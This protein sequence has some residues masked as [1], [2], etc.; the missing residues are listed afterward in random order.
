MEFLVPWRNAPHFVVKNDAVKVLVLN[1]FLFS[2]THVINIVGE[3]SY[4]DAID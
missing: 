4:I 2:S 3:G 1:V